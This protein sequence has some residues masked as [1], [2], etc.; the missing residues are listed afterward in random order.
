MSNKTLTTQLNTSILFYLIY[1]FRD[2]TMK[3]FLC[4]S[5]WYSGN[6]KRWQTEINLRLLRWLQNASWN[7]C[8]PPSNVV[9]RWNCYVPLWLHGLVLS[10]FTE[11]G[12][13]DCWADNA[14]LCRFARHEP[15][16]CQQVIQQRQPDEVR[17]K[18]LS[19]TSACLLIALSLCGQHSIIIGIVQI[20][21]QQTFAHGHPSAVTILSP[22]ARR[23]AT[24]DD[25]Q[26]ALWRRHLY[27]AARSVTYRNTVLTNT[28]AINAIVSQHVKRSVLTSKPASYLLRLRFSHCWS[29]GRRA[30]STNSDHWPLSE[31]HSSWLAS[32]PLSRM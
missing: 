15:L 30:F 21:N 24:A 3:D 32:R 18:Q 6:W 10:I 25:A 14:H 7:D 22:T 16:T 2:R 12:L 8:N 4:K 31:H 1:S 23:K 9:N 13:F 11:L 19:W 5:V 27:A 29:T 20:Q 26:F 28:K 17:R